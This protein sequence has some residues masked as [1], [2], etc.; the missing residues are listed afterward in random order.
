M[1]LS[2]LHSK[3]NHCSIELE[4][5][6]E[7]HCITVKAVNVFTALLCFSIAAHVPR[8]SKKSILSVANVDRFVAL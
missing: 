2:D 1:Y 5:L 7:L 3:R 4:Y 6:G 8:Y